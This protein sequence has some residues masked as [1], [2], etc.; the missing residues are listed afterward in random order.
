M[1]VK[2]LQVQYRDPSPAGEGSR[3]V[4]LLEEAGKTA[5]GWAKGLREAQETGWELRRCLELIGAA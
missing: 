4:G 2:W 3:G 1:R 5:G